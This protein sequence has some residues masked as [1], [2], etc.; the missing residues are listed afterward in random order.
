MKKRIFAWLLVL[1]F[2]VGLTA[3]AKPLLDDDAIFV[4][5]DNWTVSSDEAYVEYGG[6]YSAPYEVAL[7][8]HCFEEL[9]PN[10]ITKS[11]AKSLGWVSR[12]GNLWK[13]AK[14][15]SIGG[16]NFY[17]REDQIPEIV[18]KLCWECDVNYEGGYRAEERLVFSDDG[19][20]YYTND[21]Y[22]TFTQLYDGWYYADGYY[23]GIGEYYE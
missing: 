15:R 2:C 17:P 21:H 8:L 12:K 3:F 20:I 9:P 4:D 6:E 23:R 10:F 14:G 18:G 16:D 7:Y 11:D 5:T 22:T 19:E 13:V 1:L